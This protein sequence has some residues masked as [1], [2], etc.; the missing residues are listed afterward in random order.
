M[1]NFYCVLI[2]SFVLFSSFAQREMSDEQFNSLTKAQQD[3]YLRVKKADSLKTLR[4]MDFLSKNGLQQRVVRDNGKTLVLTNVVDGKPIYTATDN[5]D[6]A[7][8]TGTNHLWSGGSLGLDLDGSGITVRVWDGGPVQTSHVEFQ[9]E[10]NTLSRVTNIEAL[11]TDGQAQQDQHGTHVTG[12]IS[13]KGVNASAT[14]MASGVTVKTYNFLND[15][16]EMVVETADMTNPMLLSNHSY[17]VPI[18]QNGGTQLDPWRMGA[19]TADAREIDDIARTNPKYLVVMSAGNSGSVNYPGGLAAGF[20]KLTGDK[21]AKNN[22]VIANASPS[23]NPFTQDVT[24][25]INSGSSQGPTDDIRIKPDLAGDGTG[26]LSTSPG[27]GYA[28]LTG[29]S[30][31]APNVTGSLALLQQ[32]Y[33]QLH[34]VYMNSATLKGL[35]C[36]TANDDS[37][38][39]GPDPFFGWGLL[40]A[41]RSAEVI[42]EDNNGLAILEELTLDNG[43]TYTY[44]FGAQAG[45]KLSATICWTDV[46]GVVATNGV[47]NDQAARIVNDLDIRITKDGTTYFPWKL[48]YTGTGFTNSKGDNLV[49]NVERVDIE[50]PEAGNYTLEVS[51]KGTLQGAGPFDPQSQ[52]FSLIV[53]GNSLTLGLSENDLARSL[54]VYPNPSNGEFTISF[55]ASSVNVDD[56]VKIDIYDM[57]GRLIFADNFRNVSS[58]FKE[59]ISLNDAKSGIYLINIKAGARLTSHKLII[60]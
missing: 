52:D 32:H 47:L 24:F 28:T 43:N 13:A 22:L 1:K 21:N 37:N 46:P 18:N 48:D 25:V 17:G 60:D 2:M 41:E 58:I 8:A 19:Y 16:P 50:V 51:H 54:M 12:T 42:T 20:D 4:V 27:D 33:N 29:T 31:S 44:E 39:S 11:N 3:L 56:N 55:E 6:A 35:V 57:R 7:I 49:D 15:S 14:G 30:M 38:N 40:D 10:T 59:T 23:I 9:N 45:D 53:T 5:M 34:G 36:H 26:L